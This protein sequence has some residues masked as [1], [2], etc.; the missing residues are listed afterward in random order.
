[1]FN[2]DVYKRQILEGDKA[3]VFGKINVTELAVALAEENCQILTMQERDES[4]E[5]YYMGL[6]GGGRNE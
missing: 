6:I 1:M 3:D 4:L 2:L 5:S